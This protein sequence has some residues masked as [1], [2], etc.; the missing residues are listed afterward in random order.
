MTS[1]GYIGKLVDTGCQCKC[2]NCFS[3][4]QVDE[5]RRHLAKWDVPLAERRSRLVAFLHKRLCRPEDE[6]A[7]KLGGR[8]FDLFVN[9]QADRVGA[10]ITTRICPHALALLVGVSRH[11]LENVARSFDEASGKVY[12]AYVRNTV[13]KCSAMSVLCSPTYGQFLVVLLLNGIG[14]TNLQKTLRPV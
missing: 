8:H 6:K 2:G 14:K 5:L 12:E 4:F 1:P 3:R 11:F 9:L 13:Y 7:R 10:G